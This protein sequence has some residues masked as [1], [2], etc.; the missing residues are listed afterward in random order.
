ML[1][2]PDCA[3]FAQLVVLP[4]SQVAGKTLRQMALRKNS[5]VEPVML[6]KGNDDI[7]GD[8]SDKIFEPGDII[9]VF[10]LWE[11]IEK[12]QDNADFILASDI[13][14]KTPNKRMTRN[15][16]LTLAGV[17]TAVLMGVS[18][19]VALMTGA[20]ALWLLKVVTIDDSYR[21]VDWR[22]VFLIAGLIPL[23][24][25]MEKTG[26]AALI[27]NHVTAM[28]EGGHVLL[29]MFAVALLTTLFS[30]FM[31]NV[32][33]TVFLVPLVI[34]IARSAGIEPAPMALLVAICTSNSF[35]LPTHQVN[36]FLM[37]P[38]GYHTR[39]YLK[40]GGIMTILFLV[41]SVFAV[42]LVYMV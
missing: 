23:G 27:S 13:E 33:A 15:T 1:R 19:P 36:A 11:K 37:V 2:D 5:D 34:G 39:D 10:G 30:L 24:S 21:A 20:A 25:A 18:L 35:I 22:T 7:R 3:G 42:Y 41:V 16:S 38:G 9:V 17:L 29:I 6:L 40:T 4:G 28:L 8:F 32:A 31:S 26:A 12:F 14:G